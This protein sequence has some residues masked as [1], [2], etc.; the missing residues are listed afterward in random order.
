L[1][2]SRSA[3]IRNASAMPFAIYGIVAY[4]RWPQPRDDSGRPALDFPTSLASTE[5]TQFVFH[6]N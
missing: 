5:R 2:S 4:R 1:A 6:Q 3:S